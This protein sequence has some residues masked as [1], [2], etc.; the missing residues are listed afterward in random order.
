MGEHI[1][2]IDYWLDCRRFVRKT[3]G[4]VLEE[5]QPTAAVFQ[6]VNQ[7]LYYGL[8]LEKKKRKKES[9]LKSEL[10]LSL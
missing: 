7:Q 2:G 1:S 5:M 4:G 9:R 3:E 8:Q 6:L 10:N